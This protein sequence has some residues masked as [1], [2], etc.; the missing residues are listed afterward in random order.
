MTPLLAATYPKPPESE[1]ALQA[2]LLAAVVLALGVFAWSRAELVRRGLFGTEDPR[3]FAVLRIGLGAFT[4]QNLL[5][6]WPYRRMLWSDEGLFALHEARGRAG[7]ALAGWVPD[8]GFL[9][10]AAVVR[11]HLTSASTLLFH[12]SPRFVDAYLLVLLGCLALY[13]VGLRTR[14]MGVVCWVLLV[15]LYERN[16]LY[17]E[18]TDT[19]F[20]ALWFILLF[21][22]T[23]AAW[24]VDAWLRRRCLALGG[25]ARFASVAVD[26]ASNVVLVAAAVVVQGALLGL[27]T[28]PWV[29]GGTLLGLALVLGWGILE[30]RVA[31]DAAG[32]LPSHVPSFPRLLVMMQVA[33]I[34]LQTGM[35]KDG[36]VWRRGDALYYLVNAD[37]F[38]RFEGF[39]Q[40]LAAAFGT[41]LF[42]VMTWVTLAWEC[43]FPLVLVGAWL[44]FS[45]S[46]RQ[47]P[48]AA[49][50][51][52]RGP[53]EG[54][55]WWLG[56]VALTTAYVLGVVYLLRLG[57]W[58][59][60]SEAPAAVSRAPSLMFWSC[61][62]ALPLVVA[63]AWW[64]EREAPVR[65]REPARARRWARV[66]SRVLFSRA[67][68]LGLGVIFHGL[69]FVLVN[70]G[71]FPWIMLLTYVAF[72]SGDEL[73]GLGRVARR[74]LPERVAHR[75]LGERDHTTA[76]RRPCPP[77]A[78][79]D[80]LPAHLGD[81]RWPEGVVLGVGLAVFTWVAFA[82]MRGPLQQVVD[83]RALLGLG[84]VLLAL[85]GWF[86]TAPRHPHDRAAFLGRGPALITGQLRRTAIFC[87]CVL[88]G[89]HLVT[90]LSPDFPATHEVRAAWMKVFSDWRTSTHTDQSWRM[91]APNPP[92]AN[93]FM[94]TIVVD[95]EGR[96]WDLGDSA[97]VDRPNPWLINDRLRKMQRR[98]TVEKGTWYLPYWAAWVCREWPTR[99]GG[100]EADAGRVV[101]PVEVRVMR[102][103]SV[104][105]TPE[106]TWE[107]GAYDPRAL[108]QHVEDKGRWRC[109]D[110][111]ASP[112][113][114]TLERRGLTPSVEDLERARAIAEDERARGEQRRRVWL[115]SRGPQGEDPSTLE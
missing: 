32:S 21:A 64:L 103:W 1:L 37:H 83:T 44:R 84:L 20:R 46:A 75:L 51:R 97:L 27:Q 2:W 45:A 111:R 25:S 104:I 10:V 95:A 106:K 68:W 57:P 78:V 82:A 29:I 31:P 85:G 66:A 4:I 96:A 13:V 60:A 18:G 107:A 34:Y 56:T 24:S 40:Q 89:G 53:S 98:M 77:P 59:V 70:I 92:R 9:D 14:V 80:D 61:S 74:W 62:V 73:A 58:I 48:W 39:S 63:G 71:L 72:F 5:N 69:L 11:F 22:R 109:D 112:S 102:V 55:R 114:P 105:P 81:G 115:D 94:V 26:R 15:A 100:P 90:V 16:A 88:H 36:D 101:R 65:S 41:N 3:T 17:H 91:F 35:V 67:T 30:A 7:T 54:A 33:G 8:E 43:W 12:G 6:L 19:V 50:G 87:F 76:P 49:A 93:N 113:L 99:V 28:A 38:Y 108:E 86:G 110:D 23:D 42:R 79:R 52:L 47:Q